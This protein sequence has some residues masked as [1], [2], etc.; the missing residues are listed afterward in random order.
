MVYEGVYRREDDGMINWR[1]GEIYTKEIHSSVKLYR[2]LN[3]PCQ[4][5]YQL[6]KIKLFQA[7]IEEETT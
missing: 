5:G 2:V 3:L 6:N 4:F 1:P 7:P